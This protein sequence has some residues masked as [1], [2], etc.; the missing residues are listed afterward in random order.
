MCTFIAI[1]LTLEI[2]LRPELFQSTALT[3]ALPC[4]AVR[5]CEGGRK[6]Q[7]GSCP[8][9]GRLLFSPQAWAKPLVAPSTHRLGHGRRQL[10]KPGFHHCVCQVAAGRE[11]PKTSTRKKNHCRSRVLQGLFVVGLQKAVQGCLWLNRVAPAGDASVLCCSSQRG[12]AGVGFWWDG[13]LGAWELPASPGPAGCRG[14]PKPRG[15]PH[16]IFFPEEVSP[17]DASRPRAARQG[18]FNPSFTI[19]V[20]ASKGRNSRNPPALLQGGFWESTIEPAKRAACWH[21]WVLPTSGI[22]GLPGD[23]SASL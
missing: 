16:G 23:S 22:A 1:Q 6:Q 5:L 3:P 9:A 13:M 2:R 10:S 7:P 15:L 19:S 14:F 20:P 18:I 8:G 17:S 21:P 4:Q 12:A 11:L